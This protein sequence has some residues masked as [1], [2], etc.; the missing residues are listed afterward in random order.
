MS[1]G[2][3]VARL[4]RAAP[5]LSVGMVTA[6]LLRLGSEIQL[7]EDAGV[8]AVHFDVM[9]GVF[10][11]MMTIGPPVVK[12]VRTAMVK[13]VHLMVDDP[14]PKLG[15]FVAAGA[16]VVTLHVEATRHPHRAL[17]ELA[18]MENANDPA[19]GLVRGIA[20]NPGTPVT[21]LDPLLGEVELVLL[22]A[23]NPGW[24]GQRFDPGTPAKIAATQERIRASGRDIVLCVDGGITRA[25]VAEVAGLGADLIVTG[26]AVFDGKTPA[27][28]ARAMLAAVSS[29]V[30]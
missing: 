18:G 30:A 1:Q 25:N 14:L 12:A 2:P 27:D 28:N 19:R 8:H 9:D 29:G 4:R 21:A 20:L 3:T 10:C 13:D 24:G 7:L 15:A 11:P 16:D 23:V 22:L 6:D 5:T 17:Q 26:S